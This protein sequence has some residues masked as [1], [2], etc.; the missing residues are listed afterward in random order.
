MR[1]PL[2]VLPIAAGTLGF[3]RSVSPQ[4]FP[5]ARPRRKCICHIDARPLRKGR[6]PGSHEIPTG[7]HSGRYSNVLLGGN[8]MADRQAQRWE[9]GYFRL[10]RASGCLGDRSYPGDLWVRSRDWSN[11]LKYGYSPGPYFFMG[12]VAL[13]AATG[14][15]RML[16]RG[17][18][19]GTERIAR[20]LWRMCFARFIAAASIFLARQQI[21]PALLRK[22]GVLFLLSLLPLILMIFWLIR[23]RFANAF[24]QNAIGRMHA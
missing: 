18:I 20:H 10:G 21:F 3:C 12:S 7:Q 11:G 9:T 17:G 6:V 8:G 4:G 16:V 15:V 23:V 22:T 24:K 2:L 13:L 1:L 5:P 19:S 14:D